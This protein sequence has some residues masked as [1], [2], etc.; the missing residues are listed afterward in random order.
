MLLLTSFEGWLSLPAVSNDLITKKVGRSNLEPCRH[1]IG[2]NHG[3]DE[4]NRSAN[5]GRRQAAANSMGVSDRG[6]YLE[7][8]RRSSWSLDRGSCGSG[9][10]CHTGLADTY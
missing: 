7:S 3:A 6:R 5:G 9:R 10:H 1:I 8:N 4:R 2:V